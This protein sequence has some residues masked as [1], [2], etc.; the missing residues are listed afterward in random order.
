MKGGKE[1]KKDAQ[2]RGEMKG[3]MEQFGF[4]IM[5]RKHGLDDV[6]CMPS[7][8]HSYKVRL[9]IANVFMQW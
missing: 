3:K 8:L 7:L 9:T 2:V 1:R 4:N 6:S 5:S